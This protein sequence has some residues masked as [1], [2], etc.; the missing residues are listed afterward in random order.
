MT[1]RVHIER[2][3]LEGLPVERRQAVQVQQAIEGELQQ[4]LTEQGIDPGWMRPVAVD[5]LPGGLIALGNRPTPV[6]LGHQIARA[7]HGSL[8]S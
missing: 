4:R 5:R 6:S 8:G 3:V 2:L 1:I 7:V